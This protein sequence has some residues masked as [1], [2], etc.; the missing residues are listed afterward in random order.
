MKIEGMSL[1][2]FNNQGK[3]RNKHEKDDDEDSDDGSQGVITKK[4]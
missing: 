2:H 1:E 4:D 3:E